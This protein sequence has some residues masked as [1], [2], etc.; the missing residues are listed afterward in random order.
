[1]PGH[2]NDPIYTSDQWRTHEA[3]KAAA[4]HLNLAAGAVIETRDE[5]AEFE[6]EDISRAITFGSEILA[7]LIHDEYFESDPL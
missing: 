2:N 7:S 5:R 3:N 6:L 1:M 4:V